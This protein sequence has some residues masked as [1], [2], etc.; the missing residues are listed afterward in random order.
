MLEEG[1]E[2]PITQVQIVQPIPHEPV[3]VV[4]VVEVMVLRIQMRGL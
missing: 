3:S 4:L 2:R 1:E